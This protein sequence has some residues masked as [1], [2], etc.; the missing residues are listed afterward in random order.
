MSAI[1]PAV[2]PRISVVTPSFRQAQFLET[3]ILSVL[4]QCYPDLEYLIMDGG[5][6]D[7][8]AAII[9]RYADQLAYWQ[10]TSDGGQADAINQGFARAT[11]DILC[12]VNSDD[13]LLP[14]TLRKIARE[15]SP[16]VGRP[17]L[18]YGSCLYFREADS[19]ARILA[20]RPYDAEL[21]RETDYIYQPSSFWTRT[22]WEEVGPLDASLHFGFDWEWFLRAAAR[23]DFLPRREILSAYRRHPAHKSGSGGDRR[24]QE[25]MGV[26]RRHGSPAQI[27]AYE[28][29]LEK[30]GDYER[31]IQLS[32]R[33]SEWRIPSAE[34][35]AGWLTPALWT[36][37]PGITPEQWRR[38]FGMLASG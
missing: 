11:G 28:R 31:K 9:E 25:I 30:C 18:L 23:C 21:L 26:V 14:G 27:R 5:S 2:W 3:T 13:F 24:R 36:R 12:W 38:C 29:A 22:L 34:R 33:L 17:A 15:L 16:S 37:P 1:D 10:S 4:G 19:S 6:D 8:S 7:G 32:R 20:A 35:I